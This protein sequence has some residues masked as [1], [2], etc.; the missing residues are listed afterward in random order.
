MLKQLRT[1]PNQLT[2]LRLTLVPILWVLAVQHLP[3]QVG[4]GMLI[5]FLTDILD[6]FLARALKQS[7][8]IGS[9]FDSL[10]DNLLIPSALIW[11]GMLQP[12]IY[13]EHLGLWTAAVGL[14][15]ASLL[16]GI[17]KFRRFANLHLYTS[18]AGSL[19]QYP[20]IIHALLTGQHSEW[21][22]YLGISLFII[23]SL[24]GLVL[25]LARAEVDEHMGSLVLVMRRAAAK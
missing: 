2:A 24:E 6:G 5:A 8:E 18:K 4:W 11:I 22:F 13:W 25:Q 17:V 19:V 3:V 10:A 15:L 7:S 14:Y 16:L 1:I 12:Q 9:K 20:F 21:L 23:S